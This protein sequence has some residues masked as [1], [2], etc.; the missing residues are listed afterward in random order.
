M[1]IKSTLHNVFFADY[2]GPDC[3]ISCKDFQGYFVDVD[4]GTN[5][6]SPINPIFK[7]LEQVGA[8]S[9]QAWF[10]YSNPNPNNVYIT[11]TSENAIH[12]N[13]TVSA[14]YTPPTKFIIGD[15]EYAV[16]IG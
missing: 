5:I 14:T 11:A 15:V 7:C 12:I 16:S 1:Y 8:D 9:Y 10:G 13:G 6:S 4:D 3:D 2:V